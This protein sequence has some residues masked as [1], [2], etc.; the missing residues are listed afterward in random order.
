LHRNDHDRVGLY[1]QEYKSRR[2]WNSFDVQR[3]M[4]TNDG[5]KPSRSFSNSRA[6]CKPKIEGPTLPENFK[7][8]ITG[9]LII[10]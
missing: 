10:H 5:I 8:Q 6:R 9:V 2:N 4:I 1:R 3:L 7:P